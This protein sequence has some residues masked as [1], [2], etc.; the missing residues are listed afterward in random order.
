MRWLDGRLGT[1]TWAGVLKGRRSMGK[2]IGDIVI[3]NMKWTKQ[4]LPCKELRDMCC[5]PARLPSWVPGLFAH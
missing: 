3:F 5:V 2:D 1:E 4:L